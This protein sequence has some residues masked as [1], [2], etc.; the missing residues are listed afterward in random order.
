MAKF[1]YNIFYNFYTDTNNLNTN[2]SNHLVYY[3]GKNNEQPISKPLPPFH[4]V[5][6]NEMLYIDW[7]LNDPNKNLYFSIPWY[8]NGK[9]WDNHFHFA[10]NN[11][12]NVH[13]KQPMTQMVSF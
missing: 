5:I 8:K 1:D 2:F 11:F 4:I 10:L 7:N 3:Y 6:K 9:Y 13:R 12:T